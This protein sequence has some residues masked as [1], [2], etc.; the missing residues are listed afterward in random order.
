MKIKAL[1]YL[2]V[3]LMMASC[4]NEIIDANL[5]K[6]TVNIITPSPGYFSSTPRINFTWEPVNGA[7]K[8]HI[9]VVK[10]SFAAIQ[11]I[12][13]DSMV[14]KNN[15]NYL[16]S[17]GK[18]E[19]KLTAMNGSSNSA[20]SYATFSVDSGLDLSKKKVLLKYPKCDSIS[21]TSKIVFQWLPI[22]NA[23]RYTLEIFQVGGSLVDSKSNITTPSYTYT[24][25]APGA[26]QWRVLAQNDVMSSMYPQFYNITIDN[27]T[28]LPSTPTPP[29]YDDAASN[30]VV[31]KWTRD[32]S[33]IGDS[34][35]ISLGDSTFK[36]TVV[37]DYVSQAQTYSYTGT[38][39]KTY[40]WRLKSKNSANT[41][42][43][44][45]AVSKFKI[46]K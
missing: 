25:A 36:T 40:F 39:G 37:N 28:P 9:Q 1:V 10:P 44:Y 7:T 8:Y 13:L 45:S 5:D 15:F 32:K 26:Y 20:D 6:K 30:P 42:S 34:L 21:N 33:A 17:F 38:I 2:L 41:T 19:W 31:L 11:Q 18:Y 12:L 24:F 3:V 16:F 14:T 27:S 29:V 46:I 23:L 22:D 4:G 35:F 43:G